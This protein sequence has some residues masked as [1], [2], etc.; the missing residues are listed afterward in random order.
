MDVGTF[1]ER[2]D[3]DVYPVGVG[4]FAGLETADETLFAIHPML[5]GVSSVNMQN[6]QRF[7][8]VVNGESFGGDVSCHEITVPRFS[9]NV[10]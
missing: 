5:F 8:F 3:T 6:V 1:Y 9:S 2:T 4:T 10:N 7:P